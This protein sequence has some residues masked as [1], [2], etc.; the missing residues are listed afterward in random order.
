MFRPL[1]LLCELGDLCGENWD[2]NGMS[3]GPSFRTER[4][5]QDA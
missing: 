1:Y 5:I 3:R 4:S 2:L